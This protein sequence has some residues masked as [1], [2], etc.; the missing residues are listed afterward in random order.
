MRLSRLLFTGCLLLCFSVATLQGSEPAVISAIKYDT[1]KI[2]LLISDIKSV[3][4]VIGAEMAIKK[5]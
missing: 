5:S 2:G 1:V 3:A 4:A